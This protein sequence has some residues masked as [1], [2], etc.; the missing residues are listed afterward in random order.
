MTDQAR[1]CF[2]AG[3]K[4]IL[5]EKRGGLSLTS[6]SVTVT[7][8]VPESPPIWPTMSLA[9]IT[10]RYWSRASLSMLGRAVLTMPTQ[11]SDCFTERPGVDARDSLHSLMIMSL[12]PGAAKMQPDYRMNCCPL[13]ILRRWS[14]HQL[15]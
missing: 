1:V 5:R 12:P 7:D 10:S 4:I 11:K 2:I 14:V 3:H 13:C 8:V 6:D 9:W 15:K